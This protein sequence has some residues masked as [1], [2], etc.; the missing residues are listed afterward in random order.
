MTRNASFDDLD[1][2][3][4]PLVFTSEGSG[5]VT[6]SASL[7]FIPAELLPFPTYRGLYV[8]RIIRESDV[9]GEPTGPPLATVPLGSTIVV[10]LQVMP[11]SH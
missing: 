9:D 7:N 8:E 4:L 2:P 3:P 5:E 10:T 1:D 6:L 11:L